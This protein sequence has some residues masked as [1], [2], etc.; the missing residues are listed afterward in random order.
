MFLSGTQ[1]AVLPLALVALAHA[2]VVSLDKEPKQTI[3]SFGASGAWWP[4]D[5]HLFPADAQDKLANFL[6]SED[7][8][9]LSSYR[10]NVGGDGGPED[11]ERVWNTE[12]AHRVESF[13]LRNGTY[14]WSRD[15]GGVN[16]LRRAQHYAVPYIMFFL[17][18]APSHI[19][20]IGASCGWNLTAPKIPE[21]VE[22]MQT[23]LSHW[24][25][26]GIDIK[27]ISPMNE[28]DYDREGCS[29]EGMAVG[30]G[31]RSDV[32]Q[33]LS[34]TLSNEPTTRKIGVMGDEISQVTTQAMPSYPIWLPSSLS[35]LS[36]IAIHNYDFPN[37]TSLAVYRSQVLE[38]TDNNPPPIKFTETCCS[39]NN[40]TGSDVFGV[41]YDPTMTNAL[42]VARY[43]WQFLTIV[44]AE[45]FDWWTAVTYLPCSPAID[46]P[47]CYREV[48]ETAG[49]NSGLV[50][51]DQNYNT[52]GDYGLYY[53]KRAFMMKH[54]AHFHRPGATRFEV[55][56]EQLP[57]G[58]NA[59]A[60][61]AGGER[62]KHGYGRGHGKGE[63]QS[64]SVLF[65]NHE[66]EAV[67]VQFRLPSERARLERIVRTTPDSDWEV[68]ERSP[69]A[70]QGVVW[71]EL[72]AQS[73]VTLRI[74]E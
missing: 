20:D 5:L 69:K 12:E 53:T 28:P 70:R 11:S 56:Q 47:Q 58:V 4:N 65:M 10:Y 22:Y 16:F 73:L 30:P 29:Q 57:V 42:I 66:A 55:P 33:N 61:R 44:Q 40:G 62:E 24:T 49:Y 34:K 48:N 26:E 54:Y 19:A 8:I 36:R 63:K 18:A 35:S 43:I 13:L 67:E 23:V 39:T 7:G 60:S 31:L 41:Q 6:F 1:A 51:I 59:F 71:F 50:Y 17:N 27:Y 64:W 38:L 45:S 2:N 15:A 72:P 3:E 14:D 32:F 46:G 68:L 9:H 37:D 52:T 74:V 25:E 21:F